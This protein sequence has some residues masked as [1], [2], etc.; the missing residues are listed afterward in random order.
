MGNACLLV[1]VV[2]CWEHDVA[3]YLCAAACGLQNGMAT[4]YSG[5]VIRTTHVTGIATD[6]GLICGRSC[7]AFAKRTLRGQDVH[8]DPLEEGRKLMLLIILGLAFVVGVVFG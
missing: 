1:I 2:L 7:V 5:A 4:S 6:I 3:P 8:L